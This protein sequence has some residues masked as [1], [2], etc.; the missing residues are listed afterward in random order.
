MALFTLILGLGYPLAIT[1]AARLLFPR[2][3]SGSLVEDAS[4][5]VVGS[6]LIAQ[7]F[8]KPEYLHPRPSARSRPTR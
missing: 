2:Q 5:R 1:A 6:S 7:G 3:A 8:A 4:G